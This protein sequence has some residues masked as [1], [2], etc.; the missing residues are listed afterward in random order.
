MTSNSSNNIYK[1]GPYQLKV[2]VLVFGPIIGV[3]LGSPIIPFI[4]PVVGNHRV[5]RF[6]I[7]FH[8]GIFFFKNRTQ[9]WKESDDSPDVFRHREPIHAPSSRVRNGGDVRFVKSAIP[10]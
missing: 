1:M 8:E 10:G 6:P 4:T 3:T 5:E 2:G 7:F 9:T